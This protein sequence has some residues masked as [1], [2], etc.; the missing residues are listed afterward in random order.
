V[1]R[2]H[3]LVSIAKII[4]SERLAATFALRSQLRA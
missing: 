1:K 4:C 2:G 3:D